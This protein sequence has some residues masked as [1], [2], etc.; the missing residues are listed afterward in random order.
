MPRNTFH[1]L[2]KDKQQNFI[3]VA[4]QEFALN[5]YENASVSK[6]VKTLGIAK[7][8]VY[9]YFEDKKDLYFFL[10]E[11]AQQQKQAYITKVFQK[12]AT[13]FFD[14]YEKMYIAGI[15]FDLKY[16]LYSI[17]LKNVSHERHSKDLGNLHQLTKQQASQYFK[18][19]LRS[20]IPQKNIRQDIDV[21]L[22]AFFVVQAS[23]GILDYISMKYSLD[24]KTLITNN[25]AVDHISKDEIH[26]LVK[27][28]VKLLKDGI[29][30]SVN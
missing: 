28:F 23:A 20:E 21:E 19:L 30:E 9:Q 27:N 17:F 5:N 24:F 16:P 13:H 15:E 29:G 26:Q 10:M 11:Y 2:S 12:S 7:G 3:R 6:I 14:L 8:S 1:R 18:N 4:L 25:Q 22:M